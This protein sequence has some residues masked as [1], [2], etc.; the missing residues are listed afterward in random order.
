MEGKKIARTQNC[1]WYTSTTYDVAYSASSLKIPRNFPHGRVEGYETL[2]SISVVLNQS[3]IRYS[4]HVTQVGSK[5]TSKYISVPSAF[6][7]LPH[8]ARSGLYDSG[9]R[10]YIYKAL[11]SAG[12]SRR[13]L[14]PLTGKNRTKCEWRKR[15]ERFMVLGRFLWG[16]F[17]LKVTNGAFFALKLVIAP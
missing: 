2:L 6:R 8:E 14:C 4:N 17:F 11:R 12:G 15:T 16:T 7:E 5:G 13:P 10:Q 9:P 1:T 3:S